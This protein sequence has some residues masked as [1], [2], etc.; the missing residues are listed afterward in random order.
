MKHF[1]LS[2][3]N[4]NSYN[5]LVNYLKSIDEAAEQAKELVHVDVVI[6]DNSINK[7]K[8]DTSGYTSIN[9]QTF[10]NENIGY[11]GA[12]LSLINQADIS[13]YDFVIISNVDLKLS[14]AFFKNIIN[15]DL[16]DKGI[17]ISNIGWISPRIF[18]TKSQ[19]DESPLMIKRPTKFKLI[20]LEWLYRIDFLEGLY[21]YFHQFRHRE[22]KYLSSQSSCEIYAGHGS[23]MIFTKMFFLQNQKL[24][25]PSFMYAEEIYFAE[26]VRLTNLKTVYIPGVYVENIGNVST[27]FLGYKKRCSMN[28]KSLSTVRKMFF[29]T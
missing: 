15:I 11:L 2:C 3:V 17:N 27:T 13:Q 5:E 6:S 7:K 28:L 14:T 26:L 1:L 10:L 16:T 9:C 4:Y 19:K 12:A 23:L 8:I 20:L 25:F 29:T 24:V 18:T 22:R 21:I